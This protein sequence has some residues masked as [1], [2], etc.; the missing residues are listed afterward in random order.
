MNPFRT[1]TAKP[2]IPATAD[3]GAAWDEPSISAPWIGLGVFLSVVSVLFLLLAFASLMRMG[4]GDW[5]PLIEP[6]VLWL[7]TAILVL[8][9]VAFQISWTGARRASSWMTEGGFVV[10]GACVVAFLAGQILAWR[11]LDALGYAVASNPAN[12]FF[13]LLS[14]VHGLHLAGGLMVWGRVAMRLPQDPPPAGMAGSIGLCAAY[15][16]FL[17]LVWLAIFAL[18][19]AD[20]EGIANMPAICRAIIGLG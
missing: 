7:N 11:Q 3:E 12:T 6:R 13:Y 17:M 20:N 4:F 10:G 1:L 19:L 2:W 16:H 14:A 9:S 5:I 18:M 8:G 15:W